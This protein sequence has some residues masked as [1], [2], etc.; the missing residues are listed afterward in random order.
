MRTGRCSVTGRFPVF[1]CSAQVVSANGADCTRGGVSGNGGRVDCGFPT[2][3]FRATAGGSTGSFRKA[4]VGLT[5]P[6]E[7]SLCV[8]LS[9]FLRFMSFLRLALCVPLLRRAGHRFHA[10]CPIRCD[11]PLRNYPCD[12]RFMRLAS[13]VPSVRQGEA[14][15]MPHARPF[16]IPPHAPP[17]AR[18]RF[19]RMLSPLPCAGRGLSTTGTLWTPGSRL[20]APGNGGRVT[21]C[22][23][24]VVMEM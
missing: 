16:T 7:K 18:H 22:I 13:C 23:L 14:S 5:R 6:Y 4:L 12:C 19:G 10:D 24:G 3:G 1:C 17:P 8:S 21:G 15:V 2:C 11:P 9:P 20:P